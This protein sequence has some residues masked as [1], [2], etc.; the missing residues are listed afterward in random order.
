[1]QL[2]MDATTPAQAESLIK[3]AHE[4]EAAQPVQYRGML[5]SFVEGSIA[6]FRMNVPRD[7]AIEAMRTRVAPPLAPSSAITTNKP[8]PLAPPP[9]PPRRATVRIQ[10][11]D[12]GPREIP[13]Q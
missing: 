8:Q 9:P 4:A 3:S 11:L 12:E 5:Q 2:A 13:L 10:G 7:I 6:R 1:M